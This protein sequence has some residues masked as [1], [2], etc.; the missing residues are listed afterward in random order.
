MTIMLSQSGER[1]RPYPISHIPRKDEAGSKASAGRPI[2]EASE[3]AG[4]GRGHVLM[5][6]AASAGTLI[7]HLVCGF[8]FRPL[9]TAAFAALTSAAAGLAFFAAGRAFRNPATAWT[10]AAY[11]GAALCSALFSVDARDWAAPAALLLFAYLAASGAGFAAGLGVVI[12]ASAALT[13]AWLLADGGG[14]ATATSPHLLAAPLLLVAGAALAR[15]GAARAEER[16]RSRLLLEVTRISNPRFGVERTLGLI[17]EKLR[18]HFGADLCLLVGEE[19][20]EGEGG[21]A[22]CVLQRADSRHAGSPAPVAAR[23]VPSP[24][25]ASLLA[26]PGTAAAIFASGGHP[27]WRRL[28]R[29][30]GGASKLVPLGG[31]VDSRRTADSQPLSEVAEELEASSFISVPLRSGGGRARIYV[32]RRGGARPFGEG[33]LAFLALAAEAFAPS[34]EN[35]RLLDRMV[36]ESAGRERRRIARD[37]HDTTI[38]PIIGLKMGLSAVREK[39]RSGRGAEAAAQVEQLIALTEEELGSLRGYVTNL[40][41][42]EAPKTSFLT[43]VRHFAE[44]FEEASG[45]PV[46]LEV[47]GELQMNDRLAAETFQMV[48]EGL[49]NVRRHTGS[50]GAGVRLS[51]EGG[52]LLLEISNWG[53]ERGGAEAPQFMP[54]SLSE[55]ARSLG[56]ELEVFADD[57]GRTRLS[58]V[59]PL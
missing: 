39:L 2:A 57:G 47:E 37:L 17:L 49:S 28:G 8:N 59:V 22:R 5:V 52:R 43:A 46:R 21:G 7:Y 34:V 55:R 33:E 41:E 4:P 1:V 40:R 42:G 9:A 32:A 50:K 6:A 56:G 51:C 20:G 18:A 30:A 13:S 15:A 27:A 3:A 53:G 25:A 54:R 14:R 29:R 26:I 36:S 19:G 44:K 10:L 38:Q 31:G 12:S 35:I 45:I 58:I 48:A 16:R 11:A 24:A 23:R